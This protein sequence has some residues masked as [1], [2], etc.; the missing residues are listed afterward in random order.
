MPGEHP[1]LRV[2]R[3]D[4]VL[5]RPRRRRGGDRRVYARPVRA[6]SHGSDGRPPRV[7]DAPGASQGLHHLQPMG[8]RQVGQRLERRAALQEEAPEPVL[9]AGGAGDHVAPLRRH[10]PR[11]LELLVAPGHGQERVRDVEGRLG[12]DGGVP[13]VGLRVAREQPGRAVGGDPGQVDDRQA[14]EPGPR[15]RERSGIAELVDDDQRPGADPAE[16]AVQV[17]LGVGRGPACQHLAPPGH[18]ACPMGELPDVES[19]DGRAGGGFGRHGGIL[20]IVGRPERCLTRHP[21]YLAAAGSVPKVG[22]IT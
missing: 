1:H 4:P 17:A 5:R 12:D 11:G 15:Y 21:H 7:D 18:V 8:V 19:Q 22:V 13:L 2:L 6:P 9:V 14:G 10:R 16:Q 3:R 20:P